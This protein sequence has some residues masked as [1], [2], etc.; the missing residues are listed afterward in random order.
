MRDLGWTDSGAMTGSHL[1]V[2][3]FGRSRSK[4]LRLNFARER[5][6]IS[7]SA[8]SSGINELH[9]DSQVGEE[10]RGIAHKNY[11]STARKWTFRQLNHLVKRGRIERHD[12]AMCCLHQHLL[13]DT[14]EEG[15]S[16]E[17]SL[18]M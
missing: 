16:D 4:E 5:P 15:T 2:L 14:C 12:F 6:K 10:S 7:W 1:R 11:M 8:E 9:A 3:E 18:Y 13:R 17:V